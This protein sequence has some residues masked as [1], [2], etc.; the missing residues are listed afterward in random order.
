MLY[1]CDSAG[2]GTGAYP[3]DATDLG[4]IQEIMK[5]SRGIMSRR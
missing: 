2:A 4:L 5:Q 1:G 3:A